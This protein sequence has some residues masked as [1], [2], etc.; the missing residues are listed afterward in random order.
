MD[1]I[2]K[3]LNARLGGVEVPD[4][5]HGDNLAIVLCSFYEDAEGE[6][7]DNGW[8][9]AATKNCEATLEAIRQHYAPLGDR[10]A[11]LEAERD[12]AWDMVAKADAATAR[13]AAESLEDKIRADRLAALL[14][15]A[16]GDRD[17]L[18]WLVKGFAGA[19]DT[20]RNEPLRTWRNEA[21]IALEDSALLARL[22]AREGAER[23]EIAE[24]ERDGLRDEVNRLDDLISM[25]V[26][27]NGQANVRAERAED[28]R[29]RAWNEAIDAAASHAEEMAD[30]MATLAVEGLPD[31]ARK[32]EAM[33]ATAKLVAIG[34]RAL[35]RLQEPQEK[36]SAPPPP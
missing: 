27:Q 21:Q 15:E 17:R 2:V 31:A 35:A 10:I 14:K 16:E 8:T 11:E 18:W 1:D 7:D 23:A 24:A 6:Q 3:R 36:V 28:E 25:L 34:I 4:A 22:E 5:M 30:A 32:R 20:G 33:E 26:E 12:H 9:E 13:C 29:D 19:V